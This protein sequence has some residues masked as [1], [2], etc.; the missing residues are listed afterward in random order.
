MTSVNDGLP[1]ARWISVAAASNLIGKR[2][3]SDWSETD[4]AMLEFDADAASDREAWDRAKHVQDLLRGYVTGGRVTAYA[5]TDDGTGVTDLPRHWVTDP[6]FMLCIRTGTYRLDFDIWEQC[7]IDEPE[8]TVVLPKAGKPRKKHT[9]EWDKIVH[10]AWKFTLRQDSF[11]TNA[12]IVRHLQE[13]CPYQEL[14]VPESSHLS[15]AVKPVLDFLR[16]NKTGRQNLKSLSCEA[17]GESG[18]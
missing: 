17:T 3:H 5:P 2:F 1:A 4:P 12:S 7:W 13:W 18:G 10:E 11:P 14:D 6:V 9:Y 15:K 8:L 16:E